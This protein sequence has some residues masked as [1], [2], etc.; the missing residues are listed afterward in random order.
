MF[1]QT[2]HSC[3]RQTVPPLPH[4][5]GKDTPNA[6]GGG[7]EVC[8]RTPS[9][10]RKCAPGW[11]VGEGSSLCFPHPQFNPQ[12]GF[13]RPL[14]VGK[15]CPSLPDPRRTPAPYWCLPQ[16]AHLQK[17]FVV[18]MRRIDERV[19]CYKVNLQLDLT[20]TTKKQQGEP[21]FNGN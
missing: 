6:W 1:R 11:K 19:D 10:E 12:P 17:V 5:G 2:L 3:T 21:K 4:P 8:I 15:Y 18:V 20:Q 14:E 13:W 7:G 9:P 16:M